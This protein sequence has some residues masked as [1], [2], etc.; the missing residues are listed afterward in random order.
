MKLT[1]TTSPPTT[2]P[3]NWPLWLS[4][5]AIVVIL[6][7]ATA[8]AVF[9]PSDKDGIPW[10]TDWSA[11]QDEAKRT[12]KPMLVDFTASWCPP[13]Q[14]MKSSVWPDP[15]VREAVLARSVP[16]LIDVDQQPAIAQR[17]GV[18]GI[19]MVALVNA[20]GQVIRQAVGYH[21]ADQVIAMLPVP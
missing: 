4:L 3:V 5:A 9:R 16:V 13:C 18:R 10:R 14:E 6:G 1:M 12:G 20:D 19:P 11:A 17:Y 2:K 7:W 15:R 8:R 21:G